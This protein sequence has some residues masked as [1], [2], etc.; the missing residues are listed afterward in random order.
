MRTLL[1]SVAFAALGCRPAPV[2]ETAPAEWSA[3][4]VVPERP[5]DP[6]DPMARMVWM[7]QYDNRDFD[8][9]W[10][11]LSD[12]ATPG[13]QRD[14]ALGAAAFLGVFELSRVDVLQDGIAAFDRAI[15]AY[16]EDARLPLWRAMFVWKAAY[17]D[18]DEARVAEAYD[19]LRETGEPYAGF[20]LF[21]MTMSVA[22]DR[23]AD[24]ELVKEGLDAYQ[25]IFDSTLSY[26]VGD[27][28]WRANR[29]GD[30]SH[31][32]YNQPGTGAL[33]G[34]LLLLDGDVDGAEEA[35]WQALNTNLAYKWPFRSVVEERMGRLEEVRDGLLSEEE[36]AFGAGW[37]GAR[38]VDGE[39]EL[40]GFGGRIGNGTCTVCHSALTAHDADTVAARDMGYVR[41]RYEQPEGVDTPFPV[42][43]GIDGP[44]PEQPPAGLTVGQLLVEDRTVDNGD[45]T[46]T[47]VLPLAPGRWFVVGEIDTDT[48]DEE[49]LT[50]YMRSSIGAPRYLDVEAGMITDVT[51]GPAL[52]WVAE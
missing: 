35:Y 43:L 31:A 20:T 8:A 33:Y 46:F 32:P 6:D 21:G 23:D 25:T 52:R 19:L 24:A 48:S 4:T 27:E 5:S 18:G 13:P 26:Q 34:D 45:G 38:G 12:A 37:V 39:A 40:D 36:V 50:T 17:L 2:M 30:W 51:D 11:F 49:I 1:F 15:E 14:L 10:A 41:F 29:L 3:P 47:T 7:M 16:P 22:A 44:E 42:F 9:T 28:G